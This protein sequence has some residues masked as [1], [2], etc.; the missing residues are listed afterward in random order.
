MFRDV[1]VVSFIFE[2]LDGKGKRRTGIGRTSMRIV[3]SCCF[4]SG[5]L[6]FYRRRFLSARDGVQENEA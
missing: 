6:F 3:R 4:R 1:V 2:L 5:R